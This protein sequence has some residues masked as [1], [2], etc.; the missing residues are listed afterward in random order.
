[1]GQEQPSDDVVFG[2]ETPLG[3][4]V[5]STSSYWTTIVRM[6]HPIMRGRVDEVI[7]ALNKPDQVRVSRSDPAVFLFYRKTKE[8]SVALGLR[9]CET[10]ERRRLS[11]HD[12]SYRC[13]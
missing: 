3:F 13:Y 5:R 7:S 2:V 9:G 12:L 4:K 10:L 6:K 11:H 1:M 8:G